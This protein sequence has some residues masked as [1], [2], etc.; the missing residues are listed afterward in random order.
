MPRW[1][2]QKGFEKDKRKKDR[3]RPWSKWLK[4]FGNRKHRQMERQALAHDE[5]NELHD[6]S[7]KDA[8]N[9]WD[10]D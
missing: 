9:P 6:K 4:H 5:W 7:L 3:W 8:C 1:K 10:W 2:G